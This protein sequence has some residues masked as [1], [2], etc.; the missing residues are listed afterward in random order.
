MPA[1]GQPQTHHRITATSLLF[2]L[3]LP[4][5][6]LSQTEPSALFE[7]Q[8]SDKGFLLPRMVVEKRDDIVNPATGLM[9]FNTTSSCLEINL[10]SPSAPFWRALDCLGTIS[11]LDCDGGSPTGS[12]AVNLPASGVMVTVPYSG[13]NGGAHQGQTVSSTGV[14]GLTATLAP[15]AFANGAG[16]LIYTISGTPTS[17]GNPFFALSIGGQ[18][19]SLKLSVA[20]SK[21][22]ISSISCED[23]VLNGQLTAGWQ[24][25]FGLHASI[26]YNGGNGGLHQGQTVNSTGVQGLTATLLSGNFANGAGALNYGISGTPLTAGTATFTLNIGG[27]ICNLKVPV[28]PNIACGANIATNVWKSFMCHNLGSANTFAD[29]LTPSWEINGGYWQWGRLGADPSVWQTANTPNFVHGP[30]GT[31]GFEANAAGF[32]FWSQEPAP[33]DNWLDNSKTI[34]DPCPFGYRLPT[35]AQWQGVLDNNTGMNVGSFTSSVT[36]YGSGRFFG[37]G[38]FLPTAGFRDQTTGALL[39]RGNAGAYWSSTQGNNDTGGYLLFSSSVVLTSFE[40]RIIG[41]SIRCISE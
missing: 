6:L 10:G 36:N 9:I 13:G 37:V 25:A 23:A 2:F 11:V 5:W 16:T 22:T 20:A 7:V 15:G 29:P 12:M 28:R 34:N 26:P 31:S 30:S 35:K 33:N 39:N 1:I 27:K 18:S 14:T 41:S 17:S 19:C 24:S 40:D 32:N 3:L 4:A 21:G 38:L 8:S